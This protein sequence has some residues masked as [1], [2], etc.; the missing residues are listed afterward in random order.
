M[1]ENI[2]FIDNIAR[3]SQNESDGKEAGGEA[4]VDCMK[5]ILFGPMKVYSL[6]ESQI[7]YHANERIKQA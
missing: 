7:V 1:R 3:A 6:G 4:L 5:L 2:R